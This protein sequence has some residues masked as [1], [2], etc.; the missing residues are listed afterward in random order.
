MKK[1]ILDNPQ[2]AIVRGQ[3]TRG[4]Q[5]QPAV[6]VKY[7]SKSNEPPTYRAR[8]CG[9]AVNRSVEK[10]GNAWRSGPSM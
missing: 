2:P 9:I 4:T 7:W 3:E 6:A 10:D 5:F 1:F 8:D